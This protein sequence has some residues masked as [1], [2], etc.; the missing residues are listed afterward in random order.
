[1]FFLGGNLKSARDKHDPDLGKAE[2]LLNQVAAD[3]RSGRPIPHGAA[4]FRLWSA[5]RE[6]MDATGLS[7]QDPAIAGAWDRV[8]GLWAAKASWFGLHGHVWM[9]PLAAINSQMSLRRQTAFRQD[10]SLREPVGAKASAIYSIA[11]RMKTRERKFYHY[12]QATRLATIAIDQSGGVATGAL[13]IRAHA[14]MRMGRLGYLWKLWEAKHDFEI[15]LRIRERE[16]ASESGIGEIKTDLGLS[17]VMTGQSRRGL[18][19]LR[20]GIGGLRS[21]TSSN[22]KAFLARGLRK[23]ELGA[24]LS[25]KASLARDAHDE[26]LRLAEGIEAMDQARPI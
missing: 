15:A 11:Q 26:R 25:G 17:C 18:Q 5:M 9:G 24:R 4:L 7:L 19:L 2:F 13:S 6:L 10:G 23:L 12:R 16:H 3:N 22:G 14:L 8:L 1:L 21:D 20:D